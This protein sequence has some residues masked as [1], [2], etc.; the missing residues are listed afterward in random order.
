M[1]D[2]H[3]HYLPGVDDGA[4]TMAEALGLLRAA[5]D[6]GITHAVL[7]PH[8]YPGVWDNRQATLAPRFARFREAAA[9][10]GIPIA[11]SLG[12]EVRLHPDSLQAVIAGELPLIGSLGGRGVVLL[13]FPDGNIPMGAMQAC[14]R[15]IAADITPLIAHPERNKQ[16]MRQVAS[17]RPFVEMGCLLQITAASV[18]GE[19]GEPAYRAADE[20]L[21]QG[22]VAVVASDAHN[23]VHR[24]PR[25]AEARRMLARRFGQG[26]AHRLTHEL[27]GEIVAG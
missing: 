25:M 16:V 9:E 22:L 1:H 2:V 6:N 24:P 23:L 13:E 15:L 26:F 14:E 12:A 19:F 27:P 21:R 11:L 18:I 10:A 8:A 17:I 4:R 7:T 20:L 5:V 3:C